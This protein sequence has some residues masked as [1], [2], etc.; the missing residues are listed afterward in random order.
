MCLVSNTDRTQCHQNGLSRLVSGSFEIYANVTVESNRVMH[1]AL[2]YSR[3]DCDAWPVLEDLVIK[4]ID[5]F[6]IASKRRENG[7][8]I[9]D[10]RPSTRQELNESTSLLSTS[11]TYTS[12]CVRIKRHVLAGIFPNNSLQ[13]ELDGIGI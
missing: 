8:N 5:L 13:S 3:I 9:V 6:Q 12:H 7:I 4:V 1:D 2:V 11:G 10:I